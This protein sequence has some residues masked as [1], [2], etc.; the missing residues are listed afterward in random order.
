MLPRRTHCTFGDRH[1]PYEHT[2]G[3]AALG[4]PMWPCTALKILREPSMQLTSL[5]R[6]S[7]LRRSSATGNM[8]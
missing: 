8:L 2:A 1:A 7:Q 6:R 4:K 5:M 3:E